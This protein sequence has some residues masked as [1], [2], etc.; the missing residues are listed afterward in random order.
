MLRPMFSQ[1]QQTNELGA[2]YCT[3]ADKKEKQ[4]HTYWYMWY[5]MPL[6]II[7]LSLEKNRWQINLTAAT[8]FYVNGGQLR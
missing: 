4:A 5:A 6:A 8:S 2:H 7:N 1:L 3:N